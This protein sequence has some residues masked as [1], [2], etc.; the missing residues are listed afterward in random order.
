MGQWFYYRLRFL[1]E[2]GMP[3]WSEWISAAPEDGAGGPRPQV[4]Y[5]PNEAMLV[6]P[7]EGPKAAWIVDSSGRKVSSLQRVEGQNLLPA[8]KPGLYFIRFPFGLKGVK[9]V[10]R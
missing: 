1:D 3:S 5:E 8:L 9:V 10:I 6:V 4:Q 7:A 2:D